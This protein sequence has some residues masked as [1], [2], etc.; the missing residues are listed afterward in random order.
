[1][2]IS[3]FNKWNKEK[4]TPDNKSKIRIVDSIPQMLKHEVVARIKIRA[5]KMINPMTAIAFHSSKSQITHRDKSTSMTTSINTE[6]PKVTTAADILSRQS[7]WWTITQTTL[8][9]AWSIKLLDMTWCKTMRHTFLKSRSMRWSSIK[10]SW[11]SFKELIKRNR[12][13]KS[14]LR[15][16]ME[17]LMHF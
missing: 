8:V 3:K 12:R 4:P 6:V 10:L 5:S 17:R 14:L 11:R 2:P 15:K 1:M 9:V 13:I 16:K 7:I